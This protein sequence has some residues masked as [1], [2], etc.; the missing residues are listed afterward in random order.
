MNV[1]NYSAPDASVKPEKNG[2]RGV[3]KERGSVKN[4]QNNNRTYLK[5]IPQRIRVQVQIQFV[6]FSLLWNAFSLRV[7][8]LHVFFFTQNLIG[9]GQTFRN[10]IKEQRKQTHLE[11]I[12]KCSCCVSEENV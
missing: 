1:T 12:G 5:A 6:K 8:V 9:K 3:N 11:G 2:H 4:A 7:S 10:V